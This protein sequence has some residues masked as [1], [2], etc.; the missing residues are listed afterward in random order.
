MK[1]AKP[2]TRM[3]Q[4]LRGDHPHVLALLGESE[5]LNTLAQRRRKAKH[6]NDLA[7][8]MATAQGYS[9]ALAA[10]WLRCYLNGEV[11]RK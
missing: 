4:R 3:P 2:D 5:R 1:K 7:A 6:P 8:S 11:P 10:A 9:F